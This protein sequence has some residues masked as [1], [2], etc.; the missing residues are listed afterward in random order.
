[1]EAC[2]ESKQKPECW[3]VALGNSFNSQERV[4]VS[5]YDN[6]DIKFFDLKMNKII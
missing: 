3:S 2:E 6:G 4:L 1:M 5:G